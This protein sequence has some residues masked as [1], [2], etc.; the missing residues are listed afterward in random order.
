MASSVNFIL[1][2]NFTLLN[3]E[4][5]RQ[6]FLCTCHKFVPYHCIT[7]GSAFIII[8]NWVELIGHFAR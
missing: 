8:V 1:M 6:A 4:S 7:I 3:S 2:K 5:L